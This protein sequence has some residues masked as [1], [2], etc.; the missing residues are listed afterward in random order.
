MV[1]AGDRVRL[2]LNKGAAREGLV[3]GVTGPML[4][5]RWASGEET[6]V[7]P[8]PGTLTVLG[9]TRAAKKKPTKKAGASGRGAGKEQAPSKPA[10]QGRGSRGGRGSG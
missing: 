7:I 8:G 10:R 9:R 1:S 2:T 5:V 4:R 6:T 3:T